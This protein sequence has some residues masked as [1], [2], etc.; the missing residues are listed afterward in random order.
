M[1]RENNLATN[2]IARIKTYT[3]SLRTKIMARF[4]SDPLLKGVVIIGSGTAVAQVLNIIFVPILT[5]IYPPEIYGTLAVF[6]SLLSILIVAGSFRYEQTLPLPKKDDDAEYLLI[7]SFFIVCTL[8]I[9]LFIVLAVSGDFLAGIFHFEFLKPYYWLFCLGF[10]GISVYQ[11]LTYWTLRPKNYVTITQTRIAQSFSSAVSKIFLGLLAFGSFGLICGD[12]IGRMVGI[13]TLGRTIL[14]KAWR[15]IH[16]FDLKKLRTLAYEYRKFPTYSLPASF[17]NEISLQVPVL[18]LSD[19]FGF[20]VVG[21]YSLTYSMLVLPVSLVASSMSQVFVGE[22][23]ELFRNRSDEIL[24]LYKKTTKKLF[25]YG[26]P[27]IFT[28]AIISPVVFPIIFGSAWKDA[29]MF[30][31]PLS[32]MVIGQFVISTT[33]RL[34]LYG[35]NHWELAWNISRTVLVLTGFYLS[36]VFALSPVSTVLIFSLILTVMY[37]IN[38]ILNIKAIRHVLKN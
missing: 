16:D 29:G 19:F 34:E 31:L 20:Q 22:S 33:D 35:F 15:T 5:R 3:F 25:L 30:S 27:L 10:L 12:I 26:A 1:D 9:L 37:A 2:L 14:P 21:L 28:G 13:G 7:F 23:S 17:I 8:T 32:F 38:Y 24:T 18:F 36:Y 6:S 4:L 11:L